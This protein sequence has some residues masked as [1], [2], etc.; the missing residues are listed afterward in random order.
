MAKVP[1]FLDVKDGGTIAVRPKT[2]VD[3][4]EEFPDGSGTAL[5]VVHVRPSYR[6]RLEKKATRRLKEMEELLE[7]GQKKVAFP[8]GILE[9]LLEE[10][11]D[12]TPR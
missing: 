5:D 1:K 2:R 8:P 12:G 3:D 10:K 11:S 9:S 4:L 6:T 7:F